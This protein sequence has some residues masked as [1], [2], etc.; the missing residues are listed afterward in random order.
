MKLCKTCFPIM[1]EAIDRTSKVQSVLA[2]DHEDCQNCG[3]SNNDM[4]K[5][6]YERLRATN[7]NDFDTFVKEECEKTRQNVLNW[8]IDEAI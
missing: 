1:A 7:E 2:H 8:S 4:L 6:G 3:F 5:A